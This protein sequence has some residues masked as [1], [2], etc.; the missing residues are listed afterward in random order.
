MDGEDWE[1]KDD[2]FVFSLNRGDG[3]RVVVVM[4]KNQDS[5][6]LEEVVDLFRSF[7]AGAGYQE[8]SINSYLEAP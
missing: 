2:C 3:S 8:S 5:Y 1:V 7:L 6:T 4:R